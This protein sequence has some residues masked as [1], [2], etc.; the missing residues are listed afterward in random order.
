MIVGDPPVAVY[1]EAGSC[2]PVAADAPVCA[3]APTSDH[4]LRSHQCPLT[5]APVADYTDSGPPSAAHALVTA[6]PPVTANTDSHSATVSICSNSNP[7]P[8]QRV[9][10]RNTSTNPTRE[11][12]PPKCDYASWSVSTVT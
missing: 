7:L 8:V 11:R 6:H 4:S 9:A 5:L 10:S 12:T 2:P 1:T 3:S